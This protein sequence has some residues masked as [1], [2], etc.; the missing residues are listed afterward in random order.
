MPNAEPIQTLT[1]TH[2]LCRE[3]LTR[4]KLHVS[5]IRTTDPVSF[6]RGEGPQTI[7]PTPPTYQSQAEEL[8][9]TQHFG[10]AADDAAVMNEADQHNVEG[11]A[12]VLQRWSC[13]HFQ[14]PRD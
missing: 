9:D 5:R 8:N 11:D 13:C 12:D 7:L 3:K 14:G 6:A 2:D 4:L 10:D 1:K